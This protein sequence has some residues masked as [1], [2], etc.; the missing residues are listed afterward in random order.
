VGPPGLDGQP[1]PQG[2]Q[3]ETG[4]QGETGV[5]VTGLTIIETDD[6]VISLECVL[7]N[8]STGTTNQCILPR[9]FK[10]I[11]MCQYYQDDG[12]IYPSVSAG[13]ISPTNIVINSN[14]D[15]LYN[16]VY[17][18]TTLQPP[19]VSGG[20]I[21]FN[22]NFIGNSFLFEIDLSMSIDAS[23]SPSAAKLYLMVNLNDGIYNGVYDVLQVIIPSSSFVSKNYYFGKYRF[24][25]YIKTSNS[26]TL[27]SFKLSYYPDLNIHPYNQ[28]T[29]AK[30]G[31]LS[32]T[33]I[34]VNTF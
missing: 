11:L 15:Y 23:A 31:I 33:K 32:N 4:Q 9:T 34:R 12:L 10:S 30:Y 29:M 27:I 1:G 26:N 6:D 25:K 22:N 13:N 17:G 3:G 20:V 2:L 21:Q 19:T 8:D 14:S 7:S 16:I 28:S 18:V 24:K 5:S